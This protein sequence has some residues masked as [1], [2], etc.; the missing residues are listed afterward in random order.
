M[1][2]EVK[3][4][5]LRTVDLKESD[6]LIT[7]FTEEQGI[8]TAL[9]KGHSS[10]SLGNI[11]GANIFN[12]VLVSGAAITIN[13]FTLPADKVVNGLNASLVIDIP[14]VFIVMGI[15][16][17]PA[18]IKGRLSRWQGISLLAIYAGYCVFQFVL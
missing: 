9:A 4:L 12:L 16:T 5:V 1:H 17:I 7:I 8:V 11:I 13:P 2:T 14:L 10:L 15:L 6:R 18:L 3:G